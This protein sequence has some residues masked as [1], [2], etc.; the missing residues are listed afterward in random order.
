MMDESALKKTRSQLASAKVGDPLEVGEMTVNQEEEVAIDEWGI[1]D[2][3]GSELD[4][5]MVREARNEE[6]EFTKSPCVLEGSS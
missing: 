4:S 1:D 5:Q 6:M 3:S 2:L